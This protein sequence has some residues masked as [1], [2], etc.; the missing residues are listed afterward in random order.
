MSLPY[1]IVLACV[2]YVLRGSSRRPPARE[3][4]VGERRDRPAREAEGPDSDTMRGGMNVGAERGAVC[5]LPLRRLGAVCPAF[6][7]G[8]GALC[9]GAPLCPRVNCVVLHIKH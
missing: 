3:L 1:E 9:S 4:E 7:A 8:G 5:G 6:A 2:K